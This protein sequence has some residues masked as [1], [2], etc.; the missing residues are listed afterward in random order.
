MLLWCSK[1]NTKTSQE[2][3]NLLVLASEKFLKVT[4]YENMA[5]LAYQ[6]L[7][8]INESLANGRKI[9]NRTGKSIYHLAGEFVKEGG[10]VKNWKSRW[11]V[12]DDNS[13]TYYKDKSEWESGPVLGFPSKPQGVV[14]FSEMLEVTCHDDPS[15]CSGI[16]NRPKKIGQYCIH[17]LTKERTFNILGFQTASENAEWTT[18]L[19]QVLKLYNVKKKVKTFI[20]DNKQFANKEFDESVLQND[21]DEKIAKLIERKNTRKFSSRTSARLLTEEPQII[22]PAALFN[23]DEEID[24]QKPR[25]K[26]KQKKVIEEKVEIDSPEI[27]NQKNESKGEKKKKNVKINLIPKDTQELTF[28]SLQSKIKE[29]DD[30]VA[31]KYMKQ[32]L[33]E[34]EKEGTLR[35]LVKTLYEDDPKQFLLKVSDVT[36]FRLAKFAALKKLDSII[37]QK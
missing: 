35:K 18:T 9:R 4:E 17:L 1:K 12:V 5:G 15:K 29:E 30:K 21:L 23:K 20:R 32:L 22:E 33:K 26:S 28:L 34:F 27:L 14:N 3:E 13:I 2:Q 7:N 19:K 31:S 11:F 25:R 8:E 6:R 36:D 37:N 10:S 16:L 24:T